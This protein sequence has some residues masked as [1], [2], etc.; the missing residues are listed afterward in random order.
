M[1]KAVFFFLLLTPVFYSGILAVKDIREQQFWIMLIGAAFFIGMTHY[2]RIIGYGVLYCLAHLVIFQRPAYLNSM[3]QILAHVLI[4][5]AVAKHYTGKNYKWPILA[6]LAAN[7]VMAWLQMTGNDVFLQVEK[8]VGPTNQLPGLMTLPVYVGIYAAIT[9]PVL[10]TIHPSLLLL[11]IAGV[12]ASRSSFAAIA[13]AVGVAFYLW[14]TKSKLFRWWLA[15]G[16][17]ALVG[18]VG[19]YDGPTGQFSRRL[20]VWKMVGSTIAVNPWGGWGIGSYDRHVRYVEISNV[21]Y[22]SF[23]PHKPEQVQAVNNAIYDV[24]EK[25]WGNRKAEELL[26]INGIQ[27]TIDWFRKQ[28]SDIYIWQ[29]PHSGYLLAWFE[30][31]LPLLLIILWYCW[32]M[33]KRYYRIIYAGK[34]YAIS[35]GMKGELRMSPETVALFSSFIAVAIISAAHFAIQL[36]RISFTIMILLAILDRRLGNEQ[37][38]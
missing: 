14:Q 6:V 5:D 18:F 12:M 19:F 2:N 34:M 15:G 4:Y 27:E 28:G 23:Q 31:G 17:I 24:A 13:L 30:G 38:S 9:A 25:M 3:V 36:P 11:S 29:D 8:A 33:T 10:M 26:S 35:R 37:K 20:Y 1:K 22:L 21:K 16:L 32:D 7:L